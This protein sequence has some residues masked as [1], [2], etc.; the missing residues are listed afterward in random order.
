MSIIDDLLGRGGI[1]ARF[2]DSDTARNFVIFDVIVNNPRISNAEKVKLQ[3]LE[4]DAFE[5]TSGQWLVSET[6]EIAQYYNYLANNARAYTSDAGILEIFGVADSVKASEP[7]VNAGDL[8]TP[9]KQ[10]A[11]LIFAGIIG[12]GLFLGVAKK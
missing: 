11:I 1:D 6:E 10:S 8:V 3:N 12:L 9:N 2:T 7:S 5:A 4:T